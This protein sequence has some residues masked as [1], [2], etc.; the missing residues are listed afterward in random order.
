MKDT[1]FI[2][3]F[4]NSRFQ[5]DITYIDL[6]KAFDSVNHDILLTK[7]SLV[8]LSPRFVSW[9][10]SYITGKTFSLELDIFLSDEVIFNNGI[11]QGSH[12]DHS[13][14]KLFISTTCITMTSR[15]YFNMLKIFRELRNFEE[16]T[17]LQ[18]DDDQ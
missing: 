18:R 12:L 1:N 6:S 14:F 10:K 7:L 2:Q 9:F 11:P 5:C 16:N 4:N 8:S 3:R 13:I 15:T 17:L